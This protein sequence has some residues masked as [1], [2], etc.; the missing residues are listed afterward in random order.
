MR[1]ESKLKSSLM[2]IIR[3]QLPGFVAIRHEDVRRSG[4]PDLSLTG[5]GKVSWV[6]IKHGDP[7]FDSEGIQELT[8]LRLAVAGYARYLIYMEDK[9]GG[10]KRTMIVHP[11]KL[12]TLEPE[13]EC[14][15]HDHRWVTEFFKRR[16]SNG[17]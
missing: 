5:H 12:G 15:G 2:D 4:I 10:N 3:T 9:D 8:M 7:H 17:D 11:K 6:E 14:K 16:H 1:N 13:A